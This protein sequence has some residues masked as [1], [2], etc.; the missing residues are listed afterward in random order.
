MIE[1]TWKASGLILSGERLGRSTDPSTIWRCRRRLT[2]RA[3]GIDPLDQDASLLNLGSRR[4]YRV[5][6]IDRPG[7]GASH[8]LVGPAV[9]VERQ[10]DVVVDLVSQL[11]S[12][13]PVLLVGHSL[14]SILAFFMS[15]RSVMRPLRRLDISGFPF[16][17][18]DALADRDAL[19]AIDYL[20]ENDTEFLRQLF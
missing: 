12:D 20:P 11:G 2:A 13:G 16:V 17:F 15:P 19:A 18:D 8:G 7:Y 9:R 1:S 3:T 14:G 6:A 10:T 4:G 5:I